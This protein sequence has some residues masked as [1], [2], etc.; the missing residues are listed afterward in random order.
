MTVLERSGGLPPAHHDMTVAERNTFLQREHEARVLLDVVIQRLYGI[1]LTLGTVVTAS[2]EGTSKLQR[3]SSLIG[4]TIELI[5]TSGLDPSL[6]DQTLTK[7]QQ[8]GVF[9]LMGQI[10]PD[11]DPLNRR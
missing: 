9:R 10:P 11:E 4:D 6:A 1:S 8:A 5:R 3:S 2:D 7:A